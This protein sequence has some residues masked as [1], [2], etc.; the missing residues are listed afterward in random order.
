[1]EE[2]KMQMKTFASYGAL[3]AGV[4]GLVGLTGCELIGP[5]MQDAVQGAQK[6]QEPRRKEG[7]KPQKP[8]D[9]A[10]CPDFSTSDC[11]TLSRLYAE[12]S[13]K[14]PGL[15]EKDQAAGNQ[16]LACMKPHLVSYC[17]FDSLP[18]TR[19]EAPK[20]APPSEDSCPDFS[21]SDCC[22]LAELYQSYGDKLSS[23]SVDKSS[24]DGLRQRMICIKPHL[25]DVCGFER[26]PAA[27][28]QGGGE[29]EPGDSSCDRI[30]ASYAQA[31]V[32][33]GKGDTKAYESLDPLFAT[34]SAKCPDADVPPPPVK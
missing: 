10:S 16:R 29:D 4:L 28:C 3:F 5:E 34:I 25:K 19:C 15:S 11:C 22:Q 24:A 13:E 33:A 18:A 21:T 14:L 6:A 2:N 8:S 23:G 27:R 7:D 12:Y 20:K 30:V 32:A 1:M 17:R 26:L 9:D 31:L